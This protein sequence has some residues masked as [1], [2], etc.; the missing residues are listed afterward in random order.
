MDEEDL[1][2]ENAERVEEVVRLLNN[3]SRCA[4]L[5]DVFCLGVLC[6]LGG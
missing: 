1:T 6:A 2:A 5:L 4:N 3:D